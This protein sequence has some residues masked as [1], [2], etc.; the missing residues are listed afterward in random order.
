QASTMCLRWKLKRVSGRRRFCPRGHPA[1]FLIEGLTNG[2]SLGH[3]ALCPR[4]LSH[5]RTARGGPYVYRA[6]FWHACAPVFHCLRTHLV[7]RAQSLD[8][9]RYA[10]AASTWLLRSGGFELPGCVHHRRGSLVLEVERVM[11]VGRHRDVGGRGSQPN[12]TV[13]DPLGRRTRLGFS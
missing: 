12:S 11:E 2:E 13:V 8:R 1:N 10:G 3:R 9:V 6:C 7:V 4:H 5:S